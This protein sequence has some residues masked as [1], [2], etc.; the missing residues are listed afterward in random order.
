MQGLEKGL[1]ELCGMLKI[2][3]SDMKKCAGHSDV[4]AVQNKPSFKKKGT[5]WKKKKGK[6]KDTIP[7]PAPKQ[8]AGPVEDTECFFCHE[9]GH[10]KRN[11]SK[12]QAS[13]KKSGSK[14]T[15]HSSTLVVNIVDILLVDS[16][17]NSWVFDTG[18]VAHICNSMQGLI[19]TREVQRGEVD[20]RVRNKARF[21]P[22]FVG[23]MQLHLQSGFIMELNN[24][25]Y[26]P[27]MGRNILSPSCLMR[28]G[29]SFASANNGCVISKN[30]M[31]MAD[32]PIVNGLFILNLDDAS[33]Y[34]VSAKRLR[35]NDLS[36][37]YLWHCRLGHISEKRMKKLH[38][39]GLLTSFDFES[40]ETCQACLLGKMT[41][42]P[43]SGLPKRA[44]DLLELIHTDVC[45]P[46]STTARGGYHYFITFTDDFSRYGYVYLMRHMSETFEKFKEFQSEVENQRGKKIKALRSDRGGEYL[47]HEFND[48]LKS[49][50]IV[51][52]LTPPG[53]PQR[54]RVSERRNRTLLDMVRSMM[55]QS[56][57]PLSFWGYA[58]ETAAFT[59]NRAPSKSIEMT[60]YELWFDR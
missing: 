40:Y 13:L 19:R 23:V 22:L 28:D 8:K 33:V 39:D 9:H 25:Y 17:V 60:P 29:Y 2:A 43:F 14:S 55:S 49:C 27:T 58:L 56:D 45:G 11:C 7:K 34:N 37:T 15:S 1:N 3:E 5:S 38:G 4:M 36:P 16:Y 50:G 10:W 35:P 32:D 41:K 26:I 18:L 30:D 59:L 46:I 48:H 31:F 6:A 47:S 54:N 20:F 12:Y 57:F 24:C 53:T 42:S 21:A 44:T 52:Q 51:P